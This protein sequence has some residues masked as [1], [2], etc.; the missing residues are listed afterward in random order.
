MVLAQQPVDAAQVLLKQAV[1]VDATVAREGMEFGVVSREVAVGGQL[2]TLRGPRRRVRR[3]VFLP[4]HGAH[5]AHNAAVALAAVEAFFGV[6][7]EQAR[8]ARPRHGPQGLRLGDLAGPAGGR[9]RSPHRRAGRRAQPGRRAGRRRG[10]SP[11][12]SASAG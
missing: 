8:T 5:Q 6:G 4:L 7:A 3:S 11:R 1:E 10:A 2:L 12:R 9:A